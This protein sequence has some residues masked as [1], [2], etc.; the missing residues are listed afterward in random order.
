[1]MNMSLFEHAQRLRTRLI[2]DARKGLLRDDIIS[3]LM[4]GKFW[5]K[6]GYEKFGDYLDLELGLPQDAVSH[7]SARSIVA[8]LE[9]E[10]L[11]IVQ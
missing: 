3:G 1:M 2:Q 7:W 4:H 5:L 11:Y 8:G 6:L 10:S 9:P